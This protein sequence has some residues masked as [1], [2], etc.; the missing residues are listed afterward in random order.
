MRWNAP[1][2]HTP[3]AI[4][5]CVGLA[6]LNAGL[7]PLPR[8]QF[9]QHPVARTLTAHVCRSASC[10]PD[11]QHQITTVW[12]FLRDNINLTRN[13]DGQGLVFCS[14]GTIK[15]RGYIGVNVTGNSIDQL[16]SGGMLLGDMVNAKIEL[17]LQSPIVQRRHECEGRKFAYID[18]YKFASEGSKWKSL[19]HTLKDATDVLV[20]I[21]EGPA[22]LLV[23]PEEE[24]RTRNPPDARP[25]EQTV[26][27]KKRIAHWKAAM[28]KKPRHFYLAH[29]DLVVRR[30]YVYDSL[31]PTVEQVTER[32][33]S[34]DVTLEVIQDI[35]KLHDRADVV[36]AQQGGWAIYMLAREGQKRFSTI[37]DVNA[38]AANND[39]K[40]LTPEELA[41]QKRADKHNIN[42]A[43]KHAGKVH[44]RILYGDH[45]LDGVTGVPQQTD[46]VNCGCFTAAFAE[47]I[48]LGI[49]YAVVNH[50]DWHKYRQH[51]AWLVWYHS[52]TGETPDVATSLFLADGY[53]PAPEEVAHHRQKR[54][55]DRLL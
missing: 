18:T 38:A 33:Q 54:A 3:P 22:A 13:M 20:G 39:A 31:Q 41:D 34:L 14:P 6:D 29:A 26:A 12:D 8:G 16:V 9:G 44:A 17:V 11:V 1:E 47:C 4:E 5:K 35:L 28:A 43:K 42:Q 24:K 55:V 50:Y 48:A 7:K 27:K 2:E 53:Q 21:Y 49:D 52:C 45:R 10:I 37:N 23:V 19:A 46:G 25:C 36:D 30:V 15:S 40:E 51:L 32:A